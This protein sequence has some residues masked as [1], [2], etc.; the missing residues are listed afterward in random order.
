[1][2]RTEFIAFVAAVGLSCFVLGPAFFTSCQ[3]KRPATAP[4]GDL[5]PFDNE[6]AE[7]REGFQRGFLEGL[8]WSE[9]MADSKPE[10][11]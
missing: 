8:Q 1:M 2:N 7:Y 4:A 3:V 10:K 5:F 11:P 9:A 6:S